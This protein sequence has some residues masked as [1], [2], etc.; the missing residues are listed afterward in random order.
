[1]SR[2]LRRPAGFTIAGMV[3]SR[4]AVNAALADGS[5]DRA[6]W[7]SYGK[8]QRELAFEQR[9]SDPRAR[10]E[11]RKVWLRRN[12]NYRAEKKFHEREE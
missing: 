8:L 1:M 11:A 7:N 10:A 5:L 3:L 4:V 12:K 9:K 6:R 2:R